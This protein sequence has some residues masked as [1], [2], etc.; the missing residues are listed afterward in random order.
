METETCSCIRKLSAS[1]ILAIYTFLCISGHQHCMFVHLHL[2][3]SSLLFA[4]S[5]CAIRS[6]LPAA[7]GCSGAVSRAERGSCS[8]QCTMYL[9]QK[10]L[11]QC[12]LEDE[13]YLCTKTCKTKENNE[14]LPC[15]KENHQPRAYGQFVP[16]LDAYWHLNLYSGGKQ[17]MLSLKIL[18]EEEP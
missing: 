7:R 10:H 13:T 11:I 18:E 4:T 14:C 12:L 3:V 17:V 16:S 2:C 15:G 9:F 8:V 1:A 5:F 6:L